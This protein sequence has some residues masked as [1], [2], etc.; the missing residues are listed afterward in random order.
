M[1]EDGDLAADEVPDGLF[2]PCVLTAEGTL[3]HALGVVNFL[4]SCQPTAPTGGRRVFCCGGGK[5][6]T[7]R[8]RQRGALVASSTGTEHQCVA[9]YGKVTSLGD[10][11]LA[12]TGLT[13]VQWRRLTDLLTGLQVVN[14]FSSTLIRFH[15][16][17][18]RDVTP[19]I[20][21]I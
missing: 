16:T 15:P 2:N 9:G 21:T 19:H 17:I 4:A 14:Q 20:A 12:T 13:K 6:L 7:G 5:L 11:K 3:F 1:A 8:L 18:E 10:T